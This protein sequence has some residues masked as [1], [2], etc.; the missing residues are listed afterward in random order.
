MAKDRGRHRRGGRPPCSARAPDRGPAGHGG[1]QPRGGDVVVAVAPDDHRPRRDRHVHGQALGVG[2]SGRP[3]SACPRAGRRPGGRSPERP[4]VVGGVGGADPSPTRR[5]APP[6][7]EV[8]L[9]RGPGCTDPARAHRATRVD[10]QHRH[11]R[12]AGRRRLVASRAQVT[13]APPTVTVAVRRVEPV[14]GREAD[15]DGERRR[16][17]CTEKFEMAGPDAAAC[18]VEAGSRQQAAATR[19]AAACR[20]RRPRIVSGSPGRRWRRARWERRMPMSGNVSANRGRRPVDRSDAP[21]RPCS[22]TPARKSNMNM[23]CSVMTSPSMPSTSVM[24]V[25]RRVPSFSRDWCTI[26]LI[27]DAICSRMAR[28]GRSTPAIS[29]IVSSRD[30]ASR[31][32]LACTVVIEPSWPVFIACS[33]SSAA[34]SRTSPTMIRSGRIRSAL[35][36]RSRMVTCAPAL[37]VGRAGLQPEHVLLAQLQLGRVLDGDDPLVV[38]DRRRTARSAWSSCREPVPPLIRMFSRPRTQARSR[39]ATARRHRAEA[40]SGRRP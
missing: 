2:Q 28:C 13:G 27:A 6:P 36:T 32:A 19:A 31:G 10:G 3:W 8:G 26:R 40:R 22:S 9:G 7:R 18:A 17:S 21:E 20:L 14:T 4:S 30:S 5:P 37:D 39:S 38:G 12:P 29:T 16:R 35:R 1:V 34:P 11:P 24:W 15:R 23:S 25:M 33:M